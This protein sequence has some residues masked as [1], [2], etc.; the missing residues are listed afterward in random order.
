MQALCSRYRT[1]DTLSTSSCKFVIG[2]I[3]KN[4]KRCFRTWLETSML[5]AVILCFI[6]PSLTTAATINL[7]WDPNTPQP[8][9]Y[10]VFL[11]AG[12]AA[13]NYSTPAWQGTATA[14][15]IQRD[16]QAGQ[17]YYLVARAFSGTQVSGDSN[18]VSYAVPLPPVDTDGDGLSDRQEIDVYGTDP[19][20]A[21]TDGDGI[22]DAA[23]VAAGTDPLTAPP[24]AVD[25]RHIWIEAENGDIVAPMI[26]MDN[27]SA[28]LEGCV[29]APN[30]A[31]AGGEVT[32]RFNIAQAGDYIVW[33]RVLAPS[34][35]DNSFFVSM[36]GQTQFS[37]STPVGTDWRWNKVGAVASRFQ[38]GAHTLKFLKR[39][40]GTHL[41]RLLITNDMA[42]IP[43]GQGEPV[44]PPME[45]VGPPMNHVVIEAENG[46]LRAPMRTLSNSTASSGHYIAV[47]E[48]TST[49]ASPSNSAGLVAYA[50]NVTEGGDYRIWGR[51][52]APTKADDSFFVAM[53]EGTF[54][55]WN[56]QASS[57]WTWDLVAGDNVD[58]RIYTLTPGEHTFYLMQREDG[59]LIDKLVITKNVQ[60]VPQ[61][62][63]EPANQTPQ[64]LAL[65]HVELEAEAGAIS[66][67]MRI[68][69]QTNASGGAY[70]GVPQGG[71]T[72]SA[73]SNSAGM[74]AYEFNLAESGNYRVWGRVIAPSGVD[75]SFFAAMDGGSFE[76]WNTQR[77]S[78]WNWDL[79]ASAGGA[80]PRIYTLEAGFH[81]FYLMQREDGTF[82]DKLI[83]TLNP[84]FVPE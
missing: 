8:A 78:T 58:P 14:C 55:R 30:G 23:E 18:E 68:M 49:F 53:D 21:D 27:S 38:T 69:A 6:G 63:G 43:Q 60:Y 42:Y 3:F 9:G 80:D 76:R 10:R 7:A 35:A 1:T 84:N 41:D 77:G 40:D 32:Y 25:P 5:C 11:R 56:A 64:P 44:G 74:A 16:L 46:A 66:A 59:T 51:V 57:A 52:I 61:G 26:I 54:Q 48:G 31:T 65:T 28:S 19:N 82:I 13:Y 71:G 36:D 22:S 79:V 34:Q 37:W 2:T 12:N 24:P 75:D 50:F 20:R 29:C 72:I 73:P 47:P 17:T 4:A 70:V 45:P 39:E 81:T 67:P 62:Q 83:I 15:S 33:A